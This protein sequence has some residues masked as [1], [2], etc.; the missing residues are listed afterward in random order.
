MLNFKKLHSK[1]QCG[2]PFATFYTGDF[3]AHS[4]LWWHDGD[5]NPEGIEIENLFT[6]LGLSQIISEPT[7]FERNKNPS[8]IEL[9]ATDQ[10]NLILDCGTRAS[11]DPYCHHQ[12]LYCRVN[13]K[14]G[15]IGFLKIIKKIGIVIRK[16]INSGLK[17]SALNVKK[18]LNQ[19]N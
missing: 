5:T 19:P 15:K 1:I 18:Q 3:N 9:I 7:N 14:I 11:L 16:R 10:P 6:S 12:I 2:N 4:Q 8:C 17:F 13:F